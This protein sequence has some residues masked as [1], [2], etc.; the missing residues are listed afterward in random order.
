[1]RVIHLSMT[2]AAGPKGCWPCSCSARARRRSPVGAGRPDHHID[3]TWPAPGRFRERLTIRHDLDPALLWRLVRRLRGERPSILHASH[4]RRPIRRRRLTA[5]VPRDRAPQRRPLP[6]PV[7]GAPAQPG[8]VAGL[9]PGSPSARSGRSRARRER[10][11]TACARLWADPATIP[12]R[13][14]RRA[15]L[16]C[17]PTLLVGSVCRLIE[18]GPGLRA[19]RVRGGCRRGAGALCPGRGRAA[20]CPRS[21]GACWA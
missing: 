1:M 9:T 13:S 16:G 12:A 14:T 2:G 8:A 21:G 3:G 5:G 10:P 11:P 4:P 20:A 15:A 17:P 7:A 19:A 18:Q 6:L